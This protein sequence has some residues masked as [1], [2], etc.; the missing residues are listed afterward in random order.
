MKS[1]SVRTGKRIEMI[2]ITGSIQDTVKESGIQN[3]ICFVF[4]PHTTAAVT[5]NENADPD[6][7]RDILMGL[8][9]LIP[10]GDPQ[11]RHGEGNSDAHLKTS[12]VGS[13]EMVM[14]ENGRLV[15]GT[16]QSV[17][18]C[19]FDGP[20]TRKVLVNLLRNQP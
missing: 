3:G 18:F 2:D 5:I 17:F 1:F 20:R 4:V 8:N 7:P 15:L 12:L 13:S 11:Y 9:K 19:E 16:W 6:V 10:F 14:V